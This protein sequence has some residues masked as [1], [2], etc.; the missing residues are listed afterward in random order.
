MSLSESLADPPARGPW[1][2]SAGRTSRAAAMLAGAALFCAVY[3]AAAWPQLREP[4]SV[5]QLLAYGAL[6][7]PLPAA[8]WPRLFS[9]WFIHVDRKSVV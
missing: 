1:R 9:T 5:P 2:R 8:Q 3:A 6:P 7:V 4:L